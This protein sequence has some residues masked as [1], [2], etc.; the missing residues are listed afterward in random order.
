MI[1]TETAGR[2]ESLEDGVTCLLVSHGDA[3]ALRAAIEVLWRAAALGAA[4]RR[5]VE[6]E[7]ST[8]QWIAAMRGVAAELSG[9]PTAGPAATAS[10]GRRS[11][12]PTG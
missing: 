12:P 9:A 3:A 7:H 2:P 10:R 4:G 6:A 11:P 1:A 5:R 8:E